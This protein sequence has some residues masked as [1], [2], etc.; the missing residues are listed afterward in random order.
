MSKNPKTPNTRAESAGIDP[1]IL[2]PV[3]TAFTPRSQLPTYKSVLGL[4]QYYT[5]GGRE[6]KAHKDAVREVSKQIFAKYFHDTVFCISF[7]SIVGRVEKAWKIFRE[8]RR[9]F[10]E[11]REGQAVKEY[12]LKL[13]DKA[14]SLFDVGV[15]NSQQTERCQRD[16]GI[17][18]SAEDHRYYEDQQGPRMMHCDKGVCPVWYAGVMRKQ[19][20]RERAEQYRIEQNRMFEFRDLSEIEQILTNEGL[21]VSASDTSVDTPQKTPVSAVSGSQEMAA[22]KRKRLFTDELEEEVDTSGSLPEKF[23]HIR[24][25]ERKIKDN[26][27]L[28]VSNLV[29]TGMSLQEACVAVVTVGNGLF[30]RNW[31]LSTEVQSEF[32]DL[33]TL[34]TRKNIREKLNLIEVETLAKS[35]EHLTEAKQEGRMITHAIDSTTKKRVGTFATQGISVGRDSPVQLPL[36][37]IAGEKTE[38]IARQVDFGFQVLAAVQGKSVRDIYSMVDTHMTD[39]TQHNKGFADLL[40]ELYDLESPAGQLFCGSHTTLGFSSGMN[41]V[42]AAVERD[43]KVEQVISKFMVGIDLDSKNGSLAGQS[44][45]MILKLFAPEYS[46]K[47]TAINIDDSIDLE[48]FKTNVY[49]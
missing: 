46:H 19:R 7:E 22:S 16:W 10:K 35:V 24:D 11:G 44:L 48:H 6:N 31:K 33:D 30:D 18:M 27:Y 8:G 42:V 38:D 26:F 3:T 25:S 2:F 12:K 41:K 34:P 13:A 15:T 32:F 4:L 5:S 39:S 49:G 20:E 47:V 40:A 17:N 21:V 9:R 37:N 14:E 29:G 28:T 23:K 1:D 45:D 36:I 43:M